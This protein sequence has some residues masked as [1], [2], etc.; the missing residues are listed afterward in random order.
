MKLPKNLIL[1]FQDTRR[2]NVLFLTLFLL[3]FV[4]LVGIVKF[5]KQGHHPFDPIVRIKP[6]ENIDSVPGGIKQSSVAEYQ[7]LQKR[8]NQENARQAQKTGHSAISTIVDSFEVNQNGS[9]DSQS[10]FSADLQDAQFNQGTSFI[11]SVRPNDMLYDQKHE[12]NKQQMQG[13]MQEQMHQL[14]NL[15]SNQNTTQ[16]SVKT[17]Q[18]DQATLQAYKG[19]ADALVKA[20]TVINAVLIT[21]INSD[22]PSAILARITEGY[23][24]DARLIGTLSKAGER[25]VVQFT[26]LNAPQFRRSIPIHAVA[27]DS[28]TA[29][30]TLSSYTDQHTLFRYGSLFA[31]AFLENY[32]FAF[33]KAEGSR[34]DTLL[35]SILFNPVGKSLH[36]LGNVGSQVSTVLVNQFNKD[37][38]VYVNSSTGIGVLFMNDLLM[39]NQTE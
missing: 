12:I 23:L 26:T 5:F 24:K 37:P 19:S 39:P 16:Q 17:S 35:P 34:I 8:Q 25:V 27:V 11:P 21:A 28:H 30:A 4:L 13:A 10:N 3:A 38:T 20:G 29:R 14:L 31:G 18:P 32:S 36:A 7:A 6:I 1:L 15:W 9:N 2:R 22:E 33:Q